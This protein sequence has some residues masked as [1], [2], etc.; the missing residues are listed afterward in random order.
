MEIV[1]SNIDVCN[2][3][4][5]NLCIFDSK[6]TAIIGDNASGKSIIGEVIAT[7]RK[8]KSGKIIID[9]N[10]LDLNMQDVNYN[11][12]RFDIGM[13]IQNTDVTFF[14]RTVEEHMAYQLTI[15]NYKKS[16]KRIIDSLKMVGLNSCFVSR[17]IKTLS[18]SERFKVALA[19]TLSINP[20]VII[21]DDPTCFLDEANKD[22][23]FKL[24]KMMKLKYNKTIVILGND[25][26]FILRVADYIYVINDNKILIH[27]NKY[28]VL[29]SN[30]LK[31][32]NI[33]VPDIIKF[34]QLFEKKAKIKLNYRDNVNDLIKDIYFYIEKKSGGKA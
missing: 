31:N 18:D 33:Y 13:V 11:Q 22:E 9:K 12:L 23:L 7:V 17:K 34:Q 1:L 8:P 10:V 27:G 5:L 3:K 4:K 25:T 30:K 2:F 32:T 24:I 6:V 14:E 28:D 16:K 20:K 21:L 29:T 15:Y 19:T 26:D